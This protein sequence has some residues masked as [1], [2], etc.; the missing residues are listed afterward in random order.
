MGGAMVQN[1]G[2]RRMKILGRVFLFGG[3]GS[4]II[5]GTFLLLG[6]SFESRSLN[7]LTWEVNFLPLAFLVML[8]GGLFW[9]GAWLIEGFLVRR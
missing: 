3:L 9:I 2:I 7:L 1:D 5:L 6:L 8:L 4:A